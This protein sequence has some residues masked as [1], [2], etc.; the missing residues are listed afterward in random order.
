MSQEHPNMVLF[1]YAFVIWTLSC[2]IKAV[3]IIEICVMD[4]LD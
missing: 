4:D 3:M 1:E 2:G